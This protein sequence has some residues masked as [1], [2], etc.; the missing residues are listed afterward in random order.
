[1]NFCD[2]HIR[3]QWHFTF[4]YIK[5]A[6]AHP[7]V[8][9]QIVKMD[10]LLL[11]FLVFATLSTQGFAL[12]LK[13]GLVNYTETVKLPGACPKI[14]YIKGL[15]IQEGFYYRPYS[16]SNVSK[17]GC[18]GDCVTVRVSGNDDAAYKI[19][20]CCRKGYSALCTNGRFG[21]HPTIYGAAFQTLSDSPSK[22]VPRYVL[23]VDNVDNPS[24]YVIYSCMLDYNHKP[25]EEVYILAKDQELESQLVSHIFDVLVSNGVN[26][27]KIIYS[28]QG[29][30][31]TYVKFVQ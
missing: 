27:S 2:T 30:N 29:K 3:Q 8:T 1:M 22:D 6:T 15:L 13:S 16:T 24:Y 31:C 21:Y 4:L 9:Q 11:L 25:K 12:I 26:E 18:D 19:D 5:A 10:K 14:T 20:V 28:E 7:I 17:Y 23:D